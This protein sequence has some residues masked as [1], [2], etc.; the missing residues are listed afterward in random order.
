MWPAT[1]AGVWATKLK[2]FLIRPEGY[3]RKMDFALDMEERMKVMQEFGAK[4]VEDVGT[5]KELDELRSED[6]FLLY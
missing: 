4:F 2:P 1:G 5:G 6:L 3:A